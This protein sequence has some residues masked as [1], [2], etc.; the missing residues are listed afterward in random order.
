MELTLFEL[1]IKGIPEGLLL[2]TAVHLFSNTSIQKKP[3]IL[4]AV[5]F[6]GLTYF[7][8]LL[9]INLGFH[10]IISMFMLIGLSNMINH[11]EV[12]QATKAITMITIILLVCEALNM[13]LLTLI[14]GDAIY[15]ILATA[16]TKCLYG[17]PSTLFFGLS[18]LIRYL[19]HNKKAKNVE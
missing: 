9:P 1:L 6:I 4:S 18:I 13:L 12:F 10:T 2:L 3:F 11:I 16:T 8:R 15:E 5:S 14:F 19:I 17:M 7:I